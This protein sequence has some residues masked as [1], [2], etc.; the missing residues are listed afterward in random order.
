MYLLPYNK[1]N[2]CSLFILTIISNMS[3]NRPGTTHTV[4][5]V[6]QEGAL[7]AHLTIHCLCLSVCVLCVCV[8]LHYCM[9]YSLLSYLFHL[10]SFF[11]SPLFSVLLFLTPSFIHSLPASFH[12]PP[13]PYLFCVSFLPY[14]SPPII[15]LWFIHFLFST[16][17]PFLLYL[18]LSLLSSI[19][20]FS[21]SLMFL[22]P[23]LAS[24]SSLFFL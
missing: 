16:L 8:P 24:H 13:P 17:L 15:S 1:L 20:F 2:F 4:T 22:F 3:K 11:P 23:F 6:W 21:S 10:H 18:L 14:F 7:W 19:I 5:A 12:F 9:L